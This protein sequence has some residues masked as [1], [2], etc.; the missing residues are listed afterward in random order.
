MKPI[1]PFQHSFQSMF[2]L[3]I[4]HVTTA[5]HYD[6]KVASTLKNYFDTVFQYSYRYLDLEFMK[7]TMK[8]EFAKMA[9][10]SMHPEQFTELVI[11]YFYNDFIKNLDVQ[12]IFKQSVFFTWLHDIQQ[13]HMKNLKQ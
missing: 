13:E 11:V 2:L 6:P 9:N 12:S 10:T 4:H 8:K 3:L 1:N 7:Q 5:A